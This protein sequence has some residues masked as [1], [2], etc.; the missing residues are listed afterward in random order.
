MDE[1][2][3]INKFLTEM[4]DSLLMRSC[5][6][7]RLLKF[8]LYEHLKL[9]KLDYMDGGMRQIE[10]AQEKQKCTIESIVHF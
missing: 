4:I 1:T 7:F 9:P 2:I 6:I 8:G 5:I 3:W 10:S